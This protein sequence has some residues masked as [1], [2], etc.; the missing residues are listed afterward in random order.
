[1]EID[2]EEWKSDSEIVDQEEQEA[3]QENDEIHDALTW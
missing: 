2:S 3:E 1:M